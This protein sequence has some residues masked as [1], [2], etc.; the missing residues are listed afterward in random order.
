MQARITT[1]F[2]GL[3]YFLYII[4]IERIAATKIVF[5]GD[6]IP[7]GE[8]VR[9]ISNHVCAM[10]PFYIFCIAARRACQILC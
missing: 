10:D 7:R 5:T 3:Y 9:I 4:V 8:S 6:A 1:F 2:S